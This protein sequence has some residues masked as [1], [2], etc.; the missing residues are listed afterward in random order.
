M[1]LLPEEPLPPLDPTLGA[2]IGPSPLLFL[3][4]LE[5]SRYARFELFEPPELLP[6]LEPFSEDPFN[7]SRF[8]SLIFYCCSLN[9][10]IY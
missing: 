6:P 10:A 3:P 8:L 5:L 4:P 7:P 2:E 9:C 1:F